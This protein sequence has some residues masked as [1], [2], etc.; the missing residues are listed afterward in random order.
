MATSAN[1]NPSHGY[2]LIL[3]GGYEYDVVARHQEWLEHLKAVLGQVEADGK[4]I[5]VEVR[6]VYGRDTIYPVDDAAQRFAEIA[7][8]TTLTPRALR[9][10]I[11]LGYEVRYQQPRDSVFGPGGVMDR[12]I[13]RD[14]A[15]A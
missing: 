8:T 10:I 15:G 2:H 9:Q 1:R 14:R 13:E 5:T 3:R 11:A 6:S 4:I 12:L 7:E